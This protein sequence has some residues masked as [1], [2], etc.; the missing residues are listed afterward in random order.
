MSYLDEIRTESRSSVGIT[1]NAKGDPQ[2]SVKIYDDDRGDEVRNEALVRLVAEAVTAFILTERKLDE[3]QAGDG[4][5][6]EL[7]VVA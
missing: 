7:G 3:A 1:R 4:P 2:V 6:S 5:L